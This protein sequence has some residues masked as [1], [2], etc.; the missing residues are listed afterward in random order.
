MQ[1]GVPWIF[2]DFWQRL[3]A[4]GLEFFKLILQGELDRVC[5]ICLVKTVFSGDPKLDFNRSEVSLDLL[6]FASSLPDGL[7]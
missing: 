7:I 5:L 1:T 3:L 2:K 6:R 4:G